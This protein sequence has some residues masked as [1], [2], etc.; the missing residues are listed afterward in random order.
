[1]KNNSEDKLRFRLD[2]FAFPSDTTLRFVLLIVS[3]ISASLYIYTLVYWQYR[4]TQIDL[5]TFVKNLEAVCGSQGDPSLSIE[6]ANTYVKCME[7]YFKEA[8]KASW[9]VVGGAGILG[10]LAGLLYSFFPILMIWKGGWV[11]LEDAGIE[12]VEEVIVYLRDL[13]Q[14]MGIRPPKFLLHRT[15]YVVGGQAFGAWGRHSVVLSLGLLILFKKD[16]KK[17]RAVLLHELS[18]LRNKD[19]GKIFF[20]IAMSFAF[21][22]ATLIPYGIFLL[23]RPGF[24]LFQASWRVIALALMVYL[25]FASVL[26]LREFHA[27]VRASTYAGSEAV[28]LIFQTAPRSKSS[29]LRSLIISTLERLPYFRR[30]YWQVAFSFHPSETERRRVLETTDRLFSMDIWA[31]FSTGIAVAVANES[32][33]ILTGLSVHQTAVTAVSSYLIASVFFALLIVGTLGIA[34]WRKTFVALVRNQTSAEVGKLGLG[35][36]LGMSFGRAFS[37][38]NVAVA[39]HSD[40]NFMLILFWDVLLSVSFYYFFK[41]MAASAFVWLRVAVFARSP[42]RFYRAGLV[43]A[44]FCL[45]LWLCLV[46]FIQNLLNFSSSLGGTGLI[47]W[48]LLLIGVSLIS[49]FSLVALVSLWAFP[50]SAYL[51]HQRQP[52]ST[53]SPKWGFLDQTPEEVHQPIQL[54]VYP[55][56]RMG[57][58]GGLIYCGLLL[59]IRL[60]IRA[61]LPE[62]IRNS[63]ES[64]SFLAIGQT[65]LAVLM[66]AGIAVKV[67]RTTQSLGKVYGLFAAFIAGCV[68]TVGVLALNLLFGGTITPQFT[69]TVL[70]PIVNGG[71]L[72][73]LLGMLILRLPKG[74]FF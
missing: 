54:E 59:I 15:N 51:W 68:M 65:G 18:H 63:E 41:W 70:S 69:W 3:A 26:R 47:Q 46:F 19:V 31:A 64:L 25:I 74:H 44:G 36:G 4:G 61:F 35:L 40:P 24:E 56:I 49:P 60:G 38:K 52:D 10:S 12:N 62:P 23:M 39:I 53:F 72:L 8:V 42:H 34:V 2:P 57:L 43:V 14:E 5:D 22:V 16:Q 21:V 73:S 7:P 13:C 66:Q 45:T 58:I 55:A 30:N 11:S 9:F 27:D 33:F 48:L 1:M 71:T 50:L 17:F 20:S 67:A 6:A 29:G 28:A 37:L 32:F